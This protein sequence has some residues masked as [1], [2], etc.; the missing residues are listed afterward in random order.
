MKAGALLRVGKRASVQFVRPFNFRLIRVLDWVTY[1][2]WIW[3]DGYQLDDRGDAVARRSIFVMKAGLRPG[4]VATPRRRTAGNVRRSRRPATAPAGSQR[5]PDQR[6]DS[7]SAPT[8]TA[9]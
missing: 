8:A 6:R 7:Q 5:A 9:R 3:L 1:D 2:G 4:V